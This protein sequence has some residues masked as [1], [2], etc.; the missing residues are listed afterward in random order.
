MQNRLGPIN[1][2]TDLKGVKMRVPPGPIDVA[3]FKAFEAAP[4]VI[5]LGEVYTSL[6]THIIDAIEVPLPTVENFK[7]TSSSN[8]AR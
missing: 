8:S 2:P 3:T 4:T 1:S 5:S 6:Q 7:S